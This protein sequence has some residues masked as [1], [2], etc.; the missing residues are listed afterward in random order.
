VRIAWFTP[1]AT[2]S[3]IA[4]FSRHVT[5]ALAPAADVEIWTADDPPW[6]PSDLRVVRFSAGEEAREALSGYDIAVYN[7]GNHAG[8]H[9]EIHRMSQLRPG[10]VILHD[11]VLHHLFAGVWNVERGAP[12]P[13]YLARMRAYHGEDGASVARAV[14]AGERD[15]PWRCE[16]EVVRYPLERAALQGALGTV[17]HS[18]GHAR[19]VRERWL[20]PVRAIPLPCYRGLLGL[21]PAAVRPGERVQLTTI[22]HVV[23]NK[24]IDRVIAMLA[25]D[26]EL[27]ARTSYTVVGSVDA[28]DP[29]ARRLDELLRASPHVS[30]RLLDWCDE[31]ELDRLMAATDVFV[32]LR[33][34]GFESGSASLA[35]ELAAGRP[36]LCFDGGSFGEVPAGAVARV[37]AG[38][39]A[40]AAAE[41]RRLVLDPD[42][43][44]GLAA[45]A[46]QVARERSE[47]GYAGA[48]LELIDEAERAAPAL[49]LLDRI[50]AE[51]GAIGADPSLPV[52]DTIAAEL[53]RS[54]TI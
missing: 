42:R 25:D 24:H 18:P 35:R 52:Y 10:I 9:G 12:C 11:R 53:G 33:H 50:G 34:P 36:I 41:L 21:P 37:P 7:I 19:Q 44:A 40:A 48:L 54:L 49:A 20:G 14:L 6:Q 31:P 38:D 30:A 32:N 8:Y 13:T 51:L 29:L 46:R 15:G 28:G 1:W 23:A 47:E 5:A 22:G 4:E 39:F 3:A 43:R 17:T 27:A 16:D 26:A 45:A 2:R